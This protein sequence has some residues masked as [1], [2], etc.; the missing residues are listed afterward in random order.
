MVRCCGGST[1][2]VGG[3]EDG[4]QP[5]AQRREAPHWEGGGNG[6]VS[7]AE[8]SSSGVR[9]SQPARSATRRSVGSGGLSVAVEAI[10]TGRAFPAL[11]EGEESGELRIVLRGNLR[12]PSPGRGRTSALARVSTGDH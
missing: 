2:Q 6:K 11:L 9:A 3:E 1:R 7:K 8:S 4:E 10:E 5:G 12:G